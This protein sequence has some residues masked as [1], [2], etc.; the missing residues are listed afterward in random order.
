MKATADRSQHSGIDT[1]LIV[2]FLIGIYLDLSP[3]VAA[4]VPIPAAPAGIAGVLLLL[5]NIDRVEQRHVM[6]LFVVLALYL[7]S[8]LCASDYRFLVE[9]FKGFIQIAYSLFVAYGL[10][11][12][13]LKYDRDRLA[14]IFLVFCFAL[15]IGCLL[16][17]YTGFRSVSDRV[18]Y[19]LYSVHLYVNDER[20]IMTYG[21]IRPKLFTSE[22]SAV[23]FS[24]TLYAFVWYVLSTSRLKLLSYSAL[25]IAGFVLMKGPTSLLGFAA[26]VPYQLFLRSKLANAG[27]PRSQTM[28]AV[29][30]I[31]FSA[32]AIA[33]VAFTAVKFFGERV[34]QVASG[35]DPSFFFR[36]IGPAV[37]AIDTVINHPIAGIGLTGEELIEERVR[38]IYTTSANFSPEWDFTKASEV[39]NNYFWLHWIYLGLFWGVVLLSAVTWLI[40]L[41][42]APSVLFCW[43]IW[44]I[45]GQ[46]AGAYVSP[47]T[48]TVM[49]LSVAISI[50]AV[51]RPL[52]AVSPGHRSWHGRPLPVG[53]LYRMP[54]TWK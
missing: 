12:T 23:S 29:T 11:I 25:L 9:R 38:H 44:A 53:R 49:L 27:T 26:L 18:R 32:V 6:G 8:I 47:K 1:I 35:S 21:V 15:L 3:R 28:F 24:F 5:R 39:L 51:R 40:I 4:G 10:Y 48:W 46:A 13:L 41:L 22:P 45:F 2:V 54:A 20:D 43:S 7:A 14:R 42:R 19:N 30:A 34:D 50:M 36:V 52:L 37:V 31:A 33:A 16:E 17:N